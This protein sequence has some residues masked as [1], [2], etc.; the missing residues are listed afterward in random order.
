MQYA[1]KVSGSLRGWDLSASY[2]DGWE[3][4]PHQS[5]ALTISD[6][7]MGT[8]RITPEHLKK[9]AVGGDVATVVRSF[10]VRGEAAYIRPDPLNGPNHFQYVLGVDRTFGDMMAA[11]GTFVLVQWIHTVLPE[12]FVASPVDFNYVFEK[13]TTVRVQRNLSALA[14]VAVEGLYEWARRGYYLQPAASYR[15]GANVR[16]EGF[17]DLLGGR[18]TEFFGLFEQNRRVQ[19]RVRYSF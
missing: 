18:A 13:S 19:F 6:A 17:F 16:V 14:Q 8:V 5:R 3:D 2:F 12:E 11:G 1:T 4:V 7:G 10:T 15:F 9:Q